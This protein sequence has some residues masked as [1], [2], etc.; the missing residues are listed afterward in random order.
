V[1][2]AAAKPKSKPAART[3]E[4]TPVQTAPAYATRLSASQFSFSSKGIPN[5][6]GFSA[7]IQK[8]L[9][10]YRGSSYQHINKAMRFSTDFNDVSPVTLTHIL[11][12]Q[13]AFQQAPPTT[14]D[15]ELGRKV[16]MAALM[17]MA[18]SAGLSDLN[19]PQPGHILYDEALVSTSYDKDTWSGDVNFRI[20]GLK[21]SKAIDLSESINAGEGETILPPGTK[22]KISKVA[23]NTGGFKYQIYCEAMQ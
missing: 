12:L 6:K 15:V 17:T 8:S 7:G 1:K 4:S 5:E 16:N 18:R 23:R 22:F 14:K 3:V 20:T 11:N 9:R 19:E 10:A 13:R 2:T 21:G